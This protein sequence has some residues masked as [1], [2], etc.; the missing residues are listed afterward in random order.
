M[1]RGPLYMIIAGLAFTVMVTLVKTVRDDLSPFEVVF[2]RGLVSIPLALAFACGTSLR[3]Y[4]VG[5]FALRAVLGFIAMI[6]FF[7]AA[8][9]LLIADLSLISKLQPMV[10]AILAPL[11]LGIHERPSRLVWLL[12]GVGLAGC[13]L[14]LA[15]DLAVG[16]PYGLWCLAGAVFSA[17]AHVAVRGLARTNDP[18]V[19]VFHFQ[20]AMMVLALLAIVITTHDLPPLPRPAL[21][22]AV[23]GIGVSATLGQLF[24]THAYARDRAAVVAAASYSAPI[25][26]VAADLVVFAAV[27][28]WHVIIGGVLIVGSGMVLV[29]AKEAPPAEPGLPAAE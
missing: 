11:L 13:A 3:L 6:G 23:L 17:G 14:L 9:G 15:P 12:L 21:W 26:G 5:L 27:P 18:R 7:T 16:S 29:F 19:L 25:W 8:R 4:N 2:W 28:G 24:M 22:P 10:V 20:L 1:R